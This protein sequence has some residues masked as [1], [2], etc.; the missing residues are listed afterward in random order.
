[1][2]VR[3]DGKILQIK[4]RTCDEKYEPFFNV[5]INTE[6]LIDQM[7][8]LSYDPRYISYNIL[9]R[10]IPDGKELWVLADVEYEYEDSGNIINSGRQYITK[11]IGT[12]DE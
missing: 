12:N 6:H 8:D 7:K 1:M 5:D 9:L 11:V 3:N 10:A 2:T 4:S